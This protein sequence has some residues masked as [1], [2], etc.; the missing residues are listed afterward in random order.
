MPTP[1][2]LEIMTI[3]GAT[4]LIVGAVLLVRWVWRL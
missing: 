2:L 4:L 3:L 1:S